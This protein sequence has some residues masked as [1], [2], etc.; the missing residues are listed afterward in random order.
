MT[1]EDL[2]DYGD[3]DDVRDRRRDGVRARPPLFVLTGLVLG[4]IVGFLLAALLAGNPFSTANR[5]TYTDITIGS[6]QD[7]QVCWSIEPG[8]RDSPQNCAI[9]ALDPSLALPQVG[10]LVTIGIVE[11]RTPDGD[12]FRQVIWMSS[13][14]SGPFPASP[15]PGETPPGGPADGE[16]PAEGGTP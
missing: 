15:A 10:D 6:L 3:Y 9:L 8:R 13:A 16:T 11:L 14:G 5:V 7:D 12:Q 1:D 2:H 4:V